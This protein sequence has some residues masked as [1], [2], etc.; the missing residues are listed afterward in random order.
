[1]NIRAL[2]GFRFYTRAL[3]ALIAA[4]MLVTLVGLFGPDGFSLA[5]VCAALIG[6]IL[7]A[8]MIAGLVRTLGKDAPNGLRMIGR[9]CFIRFVCLCAVL[10]AG[11]LAALLLAFSAL[12]GGERGPLFWRILELMLL[13]LIPYIAQAAYFRRISMTARTVRSG[14]Y[15][16]AKAPERWALILA[17]LALAACALR[18]ALGLFS[19]FLPLPEA[20]SQTEKLFR[21]AAY[22]RGEKDSFLQRVCLYASFVILAA[23]GIAAYRILKTLRINAPVLE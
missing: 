19:G 1:M 9:V 2:P 8:A 17:L 22:L 7:S 18:A 23:R 20:E 5:Q 15:R 14:S 16:P 11:A 13:W 6:L 10:G 4:Q 21:A 12:A 3:I